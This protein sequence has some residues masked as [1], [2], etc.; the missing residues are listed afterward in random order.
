MRKLSCI[1]IACFAMVLPTIAQSQYSDY[2]NY[3]N[4]SNYGNY[5]SNYY[6]GS[7]YHHYHH[8]RYHKKIKPQDGGAATDTT[9]TG[10]ATS[11]GTTTTTNSQPLPMASSQNWY[12]NIFFTDPS[13][14]YQF[15]RTLGYAYSEGADLGESI[16]TAK[17]IKPNDINSWYQAWI[18]TANRLNGI[19]SDMQQKGDLVSAKEAFLRASNYYR[20]AGFYMV[21]PDDHQK[22][23]NAMSL[24]KRAFINATA[25]LPSLQPVKI[26]YENTALPGYFIRS[27]ENNAP[28]L[29]IHSGYD[30]TAEELFFEAGIAAHKRG[31]NVL[32]FEGPGQG[33]V[34][35]TLGLP[36]RPDWEHVVTP[37]IDYVMTLPNI[38]K[39]KIALMGISM[40]GYLAAR[41]AA[42]DDRIKACIVNGG[43]YDMS[44]S[45][46]Q[47]FPQ[48]IL[49]LLSSNPDKFN[50]IIYGQMKNSISVQWFFNNAMW[51]FKVKSPAKVMNVLKLYTLKDVIDKI[52][53]PMLVIDSESDKVFQGQPKK[54]YDLLQSPKTFLLFTR[55]EGADA[56]CQMGAIAISNAKVFAWLKNTL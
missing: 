37:V 31:Y 8:H 14:S 12:D 15:I 48:R 29:I 27:K 16:T 26:P 10:G 19:A 39:D 21:A 34:L 22:S 28:I 35:R 24:S 20:T 45:I 36:F 44:D 51:V 3:S 41:A 17:A 18:T 1:F 6:S 46:T 53:C 13:F 40:G 23:N 7:P 11:S 47:F 42:F 43:V 49:D 30:G 9:A 5:N 50:D 54:V 52:K 33:D 38:N 55:E 32:L 25:Y 4:Y 56:H 2:S